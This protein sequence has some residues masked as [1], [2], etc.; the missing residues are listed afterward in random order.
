MLKEISNGIDCCFHHLKKD[1]PNLEIECDIAT[2][3]IWKDFISYCYCSAGLECPD[4]HCWKFDEEKIG[5][6]LT[7]LMEDL[8]ENNILA[9]LEGRYV[10]FLEDLS[11][12]SGLS[13]DD[14]G[15]GDFY[16]EVDVEF[17]SVLQN[18]DTSKFHKLV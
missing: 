17:R 13:Y 6:K 14:E 16:D 12:D 5:I 2:L 18:I 4:Y 8:I 7:P 15:Y 1:N 11:S 10:R 3:E 9:D